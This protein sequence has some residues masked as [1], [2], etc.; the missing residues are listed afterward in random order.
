[1]YVIAQVHTFYWG[2]GYDCAGWKIRLR[3]VMDSTS[4]GDGFDFVGWKRQFRWLN[5]ALEVAEWSTWSSRMI[6]LH[7]VKDSTALAEWSTW[8]CRMK[9]LNEAIDV[10]EFSTI[11]W[12][13]V[14]P[15]AVWG[16]KLW[17]QTFGANLWLFL[18]TSKVLGKKYLKRGRRKKKIGGS[19]NWE[20]PILWVFNQIGKV[21]PT[22]NFE[23]S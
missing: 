12:V 21:R 11:S 22:F 7:W 17:P 6:W 23:S 5:E 9:Y 16:H 19:R 4:L 20:P 8:C 3:W 2:D 13:L 15:S 18:V 1:M 14:T 10:A